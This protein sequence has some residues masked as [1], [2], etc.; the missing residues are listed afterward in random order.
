MTG[1]GP[2]PFELVPRRRFVGAPFG[3][4]RSA[5]RGEGDEVAGTRPYRPGDQRAHIH[6][7]ASARLSAARGTDEFVVREF[8]ADEAP[9]VAVVCD[10][11]PAMAIHSGPGPG[12]DKRAAVA[13][14]A[15][16]IAA[17]AD[18]EHAD[19]VYADGVGA[20]PVFLRA[21]TRGSTL[22]QRLDGEF[23]APE[24]SLRLALDALARRSTEL[25]SGSFVF[26]VSDFLVPVPAA[27]WLH[28]RARLWDVVPVVVQDPV[29]EQS[30]PEVGG[31]VLPIEDPASGRPADLF[32]SGREARARA[33]AH[34]ARWDALRGRFRRLGF[35][36]VLVGTDDPFA[37]ANAFARWADRRRRLRRSTR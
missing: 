25:P 9:C 19:L 5:R 36:P 33:G 27:L 23:D 10:R 15:R 20:A 31:V 37:I 11:R 8:Y 30:F 34:A 3:H 32:V 22:P 2:R 16:L 29:W 12:L 28:L 7:P 35:D 4:R 1:A 26:A 6:W 24:Q 14:A 17:S 13:A 18:A 21:G